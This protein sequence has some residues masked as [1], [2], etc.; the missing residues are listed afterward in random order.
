MS[1]TPDIL[2][3][4]LRQYSHNDNSGLL[5]GFD[6]DEIVKIFQ[7]LNADRNAVLDEAIEALDIIPKH[8][9]N[10]YRAWIE[11]NQ[12]IKAIEQLQVKDDVS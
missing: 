11:F 4:A 2:V 8:S 10:T 6:Y 3:P 5:I 1:N 7:K 9:F 12:S